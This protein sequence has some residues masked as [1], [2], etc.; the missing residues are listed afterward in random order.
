MIDDDEDIAR[1]D[2]LDY[3]IEQALRDERLRQ[4]DDLKRQGVLISTTLYTPH[5]DTGTTAYCGPTAMAAITGEPISVTKDAIRRARGKIAKANVTGMNYEELPAAMELLGWYVVE[6][7]SSNGVRYTL[8]AFAKDHGRDGPF[9][10]NIPTHFA[11]ISEGEFCDTFTK[12]PC[13]L[14]GGVLDQQCWVKRLGSTWVKN[15]WRFVGF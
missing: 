7:W 11:A 1:D 13:D 4:I 3:L 5:N 10:V 9:I 6:Q 14:F 12:Q 2:Y 15:W 8:D